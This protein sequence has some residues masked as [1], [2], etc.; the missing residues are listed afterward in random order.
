MLYT[1][2]ADLKRTVREYTTA[3]TEANC[4]SVRQTF[5]NLIQDTMRIQG[6]LYQLMTNANMYTAASPAL[7]QEID[8]QLRDAQ[9]TQMQCHQLVM[10]KTGNLYL[11][12][13]Y[14][15][16]SVHHPNVPPQAPYY[17]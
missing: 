5:N 8:K 4:Q 3:A 7:R 16:V 6:D 11:G 1:I 14:P 13:P 10:Q 9:N 12:Q 15:S 2:L 17:I